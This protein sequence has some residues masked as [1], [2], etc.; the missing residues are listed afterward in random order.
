[1]NDKIANSDTCKLPCAKCETLHQRMLALDIENQE[2]KKKTATSSTLADPS[3]KEDI[4]YDALDFLPMDLDD[5]AVEDVS[6]NEED[7]EIRDLRSA[8]RNRAPSHG[9]WM[10]PLEPVGISFS[11]FASKQDP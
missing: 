10:E 8:R 2:M 5:V 7:D 9:E 3:S 4:F 11:T 1:M 6:D